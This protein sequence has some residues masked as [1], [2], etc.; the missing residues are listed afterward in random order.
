MPS[1]TAYE[2]DKMG[3]DGGAGT[4]MTKRSE[5]GIASDALSA[6]SPVLQ[7]ASLCSH[8]RLMHAPCSPSSGPLHLQQRALPSCSVCPDTP[9]RVGRASGCTGV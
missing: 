9:A 5:P 8:P 7:A 2:Q 1:E 6:R 3:G 4:G